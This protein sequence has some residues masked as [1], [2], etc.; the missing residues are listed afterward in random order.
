LAKQAT[1]RVHAF[2]KKHWAVAVPER[3]EFRRALALAGDGALKLRPGNALHFA[4]AARLSA[5]GILC[6]DEAMIESA[7][8]LG[9][10]IVTV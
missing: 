10:H 6:L 2:A 8:S 5:Q 9:I 3:E 1:A 7:K 4:I